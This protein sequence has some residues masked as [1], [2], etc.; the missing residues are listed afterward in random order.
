MIG[1]WLNAN[2]QLRYRKDFSVKEIELEDEAFFKSPCE[3]QLFS[4][5][6]GDS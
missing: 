4:Y 1:R 2:S 6:A 5:E 3:Q